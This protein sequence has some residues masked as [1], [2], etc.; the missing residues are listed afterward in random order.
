MRLF[1]ALDLDDAI[2]KKITRF[3]EGV[4]GFAPDARWVRPESLHVTLKFV[5]QKPD[6]EL[7]E[8]QRALQTIRGESFTIG[9]RGYGFFPSAGTGRVFWIAIHAGPQL[10]SLA[11]AI[12]TQMESLGVAKEEHAFSPHLTLAR[13][14]GGSG[15]P[16]KS[17]DDR[18]NATFERLQEK[19]NA[20]SE[21]DFGTMTA[22]QFFL[23]R[24]ELSAGG[25][26]YTKLFSF[27]LP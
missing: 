24:S 18:R 5:G 19:L 25:S 4:H 15:S 11:A 1:L 10:A 26:K 7:P 21:L 22:S 27:P 20:M 13:R 3:V 16:R 9:F 17:K 2:R 12:D 14:M 23:Y 8:L 6:E